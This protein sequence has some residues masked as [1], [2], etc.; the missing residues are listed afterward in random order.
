MV[1]LKYM[2]HIYFINVF[3]FFLRVNGLNLSIQLVKPLGRL[4]LNGRGWGGG[5]QIKH[6]FS[7]YR[8][9]FIVLLE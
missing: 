9:L 4:G 3:V 5:G 7:L 1:G 2:Q 6:F 8:Y